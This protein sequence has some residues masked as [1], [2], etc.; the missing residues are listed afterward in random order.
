[1]L[2]IMLII[3][4]SLQLNTVK[5]LAKKFTVITNISQVMLDK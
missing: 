1:M 5:W 2:K 3:N 4:P